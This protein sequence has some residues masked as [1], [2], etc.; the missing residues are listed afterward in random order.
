M[1]RI[2]IYISPKEIDEFIKSRLSEEDK[3]KYKDCMWY[4][5]IIDNNLMDMGIN[6]TVCPIKQ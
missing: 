6:I 5:V 2:D 4:P 3:E 1:G